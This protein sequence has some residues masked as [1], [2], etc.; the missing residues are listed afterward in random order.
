MGQV[1]I[2]SHHDSHHDQSAF[3][4]LALYTKH[5]NNRIF[6]EFLKKATLIELSFFFC[7]YSEQAI[8]K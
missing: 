7:F 4:T 5:F 6:T 2:I 1:T 3:C 8:F